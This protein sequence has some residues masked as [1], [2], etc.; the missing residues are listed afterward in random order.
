MP[1]ARPTSTRRQR[2]TAEIAAS[3]GLFSSPLNITTA[4]SS[5]EECDRLGLSE[6]NRKAAAFVSWA[7]PWARAPSS[8]FGNMIEVQVAPFA[9]RHS[10]LQLCGRISRVATWRGLTQLNV[11]QTMINDLLWWTA[12]EGRPQRLTQR[13]Q[14]NEKNLMPNIKFADKTAS[15]PLETSRR[16]VLCPALP[17]NPGQVTGPSHAD[18]AIRLGRLL[19]LRI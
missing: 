11:A 12:H 7:A 2:W 8:S 13:L 10:P 14:Q 3:D 4:F 15:R 16:G 18:V 1:A 17:T 5:A 9:R 6:W 19:N